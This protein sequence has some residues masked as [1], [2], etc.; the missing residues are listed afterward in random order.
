MRNSQL[1]TI[2]IGSTCE[3]TMDEGT[4][5]E[6]TMGEEALTQHPESKLKNRCLTVKEEFC[7]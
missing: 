7:D 6:G 4:M 3:G 5:G 1:T 2:S